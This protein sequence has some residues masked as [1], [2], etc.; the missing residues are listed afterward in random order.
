M[1]RNFVLVDQDILC[2]VNVLH[3]GL[4]KFSVEKG[5]VKETV[6][7]SGRALHVLSGSYPGDWGLGGATDGLLGGLWPYHIRSA[8]IREIGDLM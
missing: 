4:D 7:R 5:L 8:T 6:A 2:R 3:K 1:S